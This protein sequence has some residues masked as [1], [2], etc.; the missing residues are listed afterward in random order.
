M[1]KPIWAV[2]EGVY[3]DYH[4]VALFPTKELAE[5]AAKEGGGG[6]YVEEM[7]FW[8][9]VPRATKVWSID[10]RTDGKGDSR[11]NEYTWVDWPAA[12]HPKVEYRELPWGFRI[13]GTDEK[14]V[15]KALSERLAQRKA[16]NPDA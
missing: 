11:P 8:E 15:Y 12:H 13:T 16:M 1:R 7:D 6:H 14:A 4:V 9:E 10:V 5:E 2:S 3:S